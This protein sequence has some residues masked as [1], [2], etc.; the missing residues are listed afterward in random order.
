MTLAS[1][2]IVYEKTTGKLII[3]PVAIFNSDDMRWFYYSGVMERS[4]VSS[5]INPISYE[6][7]YAMIMADENS[8]LWNAV[9]QSAAKEAKAD[10]RTLNI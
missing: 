8:P 1:Y 3:G 2:I 10:E 6:A 9:Y 4:A 7:H 5:D